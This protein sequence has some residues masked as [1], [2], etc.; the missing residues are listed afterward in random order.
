VNNLAELLRSQG[1]YEEAEPLYQRA[2]AGCE[3]AL[4]PA[5]PSTLS[6]VNNLAGLL[7]DRSK[8]EEAAA[9]HETLRQRQEMR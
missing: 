4:G 6:S 2:L 9:L 1:K 7:Q 5:H 8:H 3:E